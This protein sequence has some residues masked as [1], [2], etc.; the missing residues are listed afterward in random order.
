MNDDEM[1]GSMILCAGSL[2]PLTK[3]VAKVFS[4]LEV[5]VLRAGI[6]D[7]A[8]KKGKKPVSFTLEMFF[9]SIVNAD[10]GGV[11]QR[12]LNAIVVESFIGAKMRPCI[13]HQ[14]NDL[15]T[16]LPPALLQR[17]INALRCAAAG[18]VQHIRNDQDPGS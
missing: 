13:R 10:L 5:L 1:R 3:P 12:H 2:V 18:V 8:L 4:F 9:N 14:V 16:G 17:N 11:H 7:V 15:D 6:F